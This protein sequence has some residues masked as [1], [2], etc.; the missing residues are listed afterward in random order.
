M[1]F[2]RNDLRV[3]RVF[4]VLFVCLLAGASCRS[5]SEPAATPT[6]STDTV[7]STTPPFP[8]KEP[9]RY[10]AT[11]TIT[12]VTAN[13]ETV[14]TK[15]LIAKDG[16]SRREESET[17][18]QR[19]VYLETPAG[20][21]VILPEKKVYAAVTSE[22]EAALD[23]E[24]EESSPDRLL[25]LEP[26]NTSYQSIGTEVLAGRNTR[27]YRV[28][29]NNSPSE[30]VS[31]NETLIWVDETLSM[32]VKTETKSADGARTTMELS[33]IATDPDFALFQLPAGYEKIA[34]G[35]L[36]KQLKEPRVNP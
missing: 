24:T 22:D 31:Q 23:A 12:I 4:P 17:G 36:R 18:S 16:P 26:I 20:R 35:E 6:P 27:K 25:H 7:V 19:M 34:F 2:V 32:P 13:G 10:H 28:V 8:T 21:F 11:R 29:V 9:D 14:V 3:L 1:S 5:A 30:N 33:E 15:T